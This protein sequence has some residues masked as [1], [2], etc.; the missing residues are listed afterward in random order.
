MTLD[1]KVR[2]LELYEKLQSTRKVATEMSV[3]K[4]QILK[5]VTAERE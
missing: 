1:E 3:G 5:V 4:T 2:A